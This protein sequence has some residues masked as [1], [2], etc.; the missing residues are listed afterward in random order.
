MKTRRH[1][2]NKGYRQVK[3]LSHLKRLR[4]LAKELNIKCLN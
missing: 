2:N 1:H 4:K 3:T